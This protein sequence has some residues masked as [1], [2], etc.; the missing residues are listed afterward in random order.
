MLLIEGPDYALFA[1]QTLPKSDPLDDFA[2]SLSG[3]LEEGTG[4]KS[5]EVTQS[6]RKSAVRW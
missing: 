1:V 3:L 2:T 6:K 4:F 5:A